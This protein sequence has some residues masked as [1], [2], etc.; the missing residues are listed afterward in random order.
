MAED[1]PPMFVTTPA[2]TFSAKWLRGIRSFTQQ[3]GYGM[4]SSPFELLAHDADGAETV[5]YRYYGKHDAKI[6]Y[7]MVP[8][9]ARAVGEACTT[10]MSPRNVCKIEVH[11]HVYTPSQST[12]ERVF[13]VRYE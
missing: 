12:I 3:G 4:A 8:D 1:R 10:P 2:G 9:F 5:V 13:Y 11:P 7:K 6:A